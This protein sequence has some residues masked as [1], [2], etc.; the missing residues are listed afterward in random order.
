[1]YVLMPT[2]TLL[3]NLDKTYNIVL[4]KGLFN[5]EFNHNTYGVSGPVSLYRALPV[6]GDGGKRKWTQVDQDNPGAKIM[7][8][9]RLAD[10]I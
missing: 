6:A 1:M 10:P 8:L 4:F 3:I 9:N 5:G 2:S 7:R